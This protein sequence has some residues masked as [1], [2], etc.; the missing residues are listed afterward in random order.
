MTT[1]HRP[2]DRILLWMCA[3]VFVYEFG[4]GSVIPALALYARSFG[5][6]QAAV[7]S[8]ISIYG[9]ARFLAAVPAG[10]LADGLGRRTTL[11]V[12]GLVTVVGN[13]LCA[14]APSFAVFM[15]A[16][17]VAGAGAALVLNGAQIVM[18]DITTPA[19]R[20]RTMAIYQGTFLFA[21][22]IGPLPGGLLAEWFGLRAPFVTYAVGGAVVTALAWLCI[23]ETRAYRS[24]GGAGPAEP[25][26]PFRAQMRLLIRH[27]GFVLVSAVSFVNAVARTG[28]LFA[29]IPVLGQDRLSLTTERIGLALAL[30]SIVGLALVYPSGALVDR[31]GRK[32]VIVPATLVAGASLGLFVFAPSYPWFVAACLVWGVA[33][34][35]SAGAPSA[36]TAD[37]APAGMNAAAMSSFRMLSDIGYVLG[38][39]ALGG[40]ADAFGVNAALILAAALLVVIGLAFARFAPESYR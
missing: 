33:V 34:G 13:L 21:S 5:V 16:R 19:T 39:I 29:L 35:L 14:Y 4:F 2:G 24:A 17:F 27:R 32:V 1:A 38:P 11:A 30:T 20:G 7:G 23:P 3:L 22:S 8:A 10:R 6:S 25:L 31:Y 26:P 36:Y 37:V 40:V 12:G 15:A 28:A 18:A 9:L